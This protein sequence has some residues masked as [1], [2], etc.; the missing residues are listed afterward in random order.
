MLAGISLKRVL[1]KKGAHNH[2][3]E[4]VTHGVSYDTVDSQLVLLFFCDD[5]TLTKSK[6]KNKNTK[7]YMNLTT[8]K[9]QHVREIK[10]TKKSRNGATHGTNIFKENV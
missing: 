7:K 1:V 9:T 6:N 3:D 8:K 5:K 2:S 10:L 4:A